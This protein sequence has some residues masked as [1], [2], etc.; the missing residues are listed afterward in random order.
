M[1]VDESWGG[2]EAVGVDDQRA[3][4]RGGV[5]GA[6]GSVAQEEVSGGVGSG[7]GVDEA[8]ALD[9]DGG[10]HSVGLSWGP[11]RSW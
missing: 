3:C 11:V 8:C 9:E 4:G 10:G 2:D 1:Q 6:D 5:C 7:V